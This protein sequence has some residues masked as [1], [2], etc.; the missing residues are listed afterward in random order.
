MK[1]FMALRIN[2]LR[3]ALLNVRVLIV[4]IW[5]NGLTDRPRSWANQPRE[6][7]GPGFRPTVHRPNEIETRVRRRSINLAAVSV[8]IESD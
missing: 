3:T 1:N 5:C 4:C 8:S 7:Y 6:L 2:D